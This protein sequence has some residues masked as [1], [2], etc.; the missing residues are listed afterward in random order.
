MKRILTTSLAFVL[1]FALVFAFQATTFA[2]E[3]TTVTIHY[4][5]AADNTLEWDLWIWADGLDGAA[6]PFTGTDD[7]GQVATVELDGTHSKV[8]FI[9]RLPDWSKKDVDADRFIESFVDGKAEIWLISGDPTVYTSN[10]DAPAAS[11][12]AA[13]PKTGMGGASEANTSYLPVVF[14]LAALLSVTAFFFARKRTM[15]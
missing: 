12:P 4:K 6:F 9:V 1:C 13:M 5:P 2:A 10:P 15:N 11:K 3:K 8:G 7:F 14:A